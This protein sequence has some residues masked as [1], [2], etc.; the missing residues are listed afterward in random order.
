MYIIYIYINTYFACGCKHTCLECLDGWT[1]SLCISLV[2]A[3]WP[4]APRIGLD[5]SFVAT[6]GHQEASIFSIKNPQKLSLFTLFTGCWE[7][8]QPN[9][10]VFSGMW[11]LSYGQ[12]SVM[13]FPTAAS[14]PF[15]VWCGDASATVVASLRWGCVVHTF[16]MQRV[17]WLLFGRM[18]LY[19]KVLHRTYILFSSYETSNPTRLSQTWRLWPQEAPSSSSHPR[20]SAPVPKAAEKVRCL[21]CYAIQW[22]GL[23][24]ASLIW[25]ID[26]GAWIHCTKGQQEWFQQETF[27]TEKAHRHWTVWKSPNNSRRC[28][29]FC[30]PWALNMENMNTT[31]KESV[32]FRTF[33]EFLLHP[34]HSVSDHP[35]KDGETWKL[36]SFHPS[37]C[38]KA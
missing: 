24:K 22:W 25:R 13:E 21:K 29:F 15:Q 32:E 14:S 2:L 36:R 35:R 38:W 10:A 1:D 33:S 5:Q 37:W 18:P 17:W 20:V 12:D 19:C 7:G 9:L 31:G 4:S 23:I 27:E 11:F 34:A 16:P 30:S 26:Q 8:D 6:S 3:G 28:W